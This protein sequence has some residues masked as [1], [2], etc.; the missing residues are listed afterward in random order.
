MATVSAGIWPAAQVEAAGGRVVGV[1]S[2]GKIAG[3]GSVAGSSRCR[4]S[5]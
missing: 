3:P 1:T 2:V 5:P 4:R